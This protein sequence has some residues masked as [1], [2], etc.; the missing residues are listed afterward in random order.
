MKFQVLCYALL[1][2]SCSAHHS[3][4]WLNGSKKEIFRSSQET[5]VHELVK[6]HLQRRS[7]E[8]T[9]TEDVST[10]KASIKEFKNLLALAKVME[11]SFFY[12][13]GILKSLK[14]QIKKP[15]F[16]SKEHFPSHVFE[17]GGIFGKA[18]SAS[19]HR[20]EKD[21]MPVKN[22]IWLIAMLKH[23]QEY[24]P[25]GELLPLPTDVDYRTSRPAE[26]YLHLTRDLDLIRVGQSLWTLDVVKPELVDMDPSLA[27]VITRMEMIKWV[28]PRRK[29]LGHTQLS[30]FML[31]T[32]NDLVKESCPMPGT[33][34]EELVQRC[35][36]I[37][38]MPNT[39]EQDKDLAYTVL[40]E[41][42]KFSHRAKR[43]VEVKKAQDLAFKELFEDEDSVRT[44]AN[45]W[46]DHMNCYIRAKVID[47]IKP[48]L[49]NKDDSRLSSFILEARW[50]LLEGDGLIIDSKLRSFLRKCL[51][52]ARQDNMANV[53]K[54][55]AYQVLYALSK[56]SPR[57]KEAMECIKAQVPSFMK[58]HR[59]EELKKTITNLWLQHKHTKYAK[60]IEP[61]FRHPKFGF[62]HFQR[63]IEALRE[64]SFCPDIFRKEPM[65]EDILIT[66]LYRFSDHIDGAK[67]YL[68]GKVKWNVEA[69]TYQV[70]D[71]EET[72]NPSGRDICTICL[73]PLRSN[74]NVHNSLTDHDVVVDL[75]HGGHSHRFHKTCLLELKKKRTNYAKPL[76]CPLCRH[77]IKFTLTIR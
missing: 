49:K 46:K 73:E 28:G 31:E 18:I 56:V 13:S 14:S 1:T 29:R 24:L 16:S 68:D 5:S 74:D 34:L 42:S 26:L 23:L 54:E 66:L 58:V 32:Y 40:F 25:Q 19:V 71:P 2:I 39:S 7:N 77:P 35:L 8:I 10:K 59:Y 45:D 15:L 4:I 57:A 75:N 20:L 63:T 43:I 3:N 55:V 69:Q 50:Q 44:L 62:I 65:S 22:K 52:Y 41:Y 11:I 21:D 60:L 33:Q 61:F 12:L 27:E 9:L 72:D 51:L 38:I 70:K 37:A 76:K 36:Q 30:Q 6:H 17:E 47:R 67:A 53:N 48:Q 64:G